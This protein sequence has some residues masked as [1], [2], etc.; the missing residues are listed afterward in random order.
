MTAALETKAIVIPGPGRAELRDLT[1]PV[2][3]PQTVRVRVELCGV[4][5]PEQR[6]FRG[7][8]RG[9]PYWGGHEIS[10]IVESDETPYTGLEPGTRVALGLMPRCG[11]CAH[12][13]RHL[14]NHCAY[15]HGAAGSRREAGLSGP[16]GFAT[17]IAV[18]PYKVFAYP[19]GVPPETVAL[20]EP[21]ACCLRSVRAAAPAPGDLVAIYG[22]GTM[23]RLHASLAAVAGCRVLVFDDDAGS[24]QAIESFDALH[25]GPLDPAHVA[26]VVREAS[27][28]NGVAAAFCTR[29]GRQSIELAVRTSARGG[30][31]VL[32]QSLPDARPVEIDV[33]DLHY[34][35]I[36]LVGTIAQ[37][38]SDLAEARNFLSART[39]FHRTLAVE[40]AS[41]RDPET[42][43]RRA[44]DPA[45]NRVMIDFRGL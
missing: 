42:A 35:E 32:F 23:G 20:T 37:T 39:D 44:T 14:D 26:E 19:P 5:T 9:Y 30:T 6:V 21:L 1:V 7:A 15:V 13:R 18:E 24:R 3:D 27:G 17:R 43:L 29:G 31:V 40:T 2:T 38:A 12:C 4:C 11:A 45:V 34:R 10:G 22:A 36:R 41:A 25:V 8:G 28:G 33:N 16:G